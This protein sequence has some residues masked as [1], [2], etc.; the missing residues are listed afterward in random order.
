M[1]DMTMNTTE[2][3]R[4]ETCA[5]TQEEIALNQRLYAACV[6]KAP[7]F[8]AIERLLALGVD[9]LGAMGASDDAMTEHVY[10]EIICDTLDDDNANLPHI[11]AMFLAH[12]M[13]VDRPRIPYDQEHS[14]NPMWELAFASNDNALRALKLLLDRGLSSDSA[15]LVWEHALTDLVLARANPVND[16]FWRDAYAWVVKAMML[17]ASYEH[18]GGHDESL[19]ERINCAQNSGDLL[20]F[21]RWDEFDCRFSAA[22]DA[23]FLVRIVER[24]SRKEVWHLRIGG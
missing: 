14:L 15:A 1:G 6:R 2:N 9:P 21:R 23:S 11:T 18:I 13:D 12:G 7:D 22:S 24:E 10:G 20:R 3:S 19:R 4:M 8:D 16:S 5:Y 17:C